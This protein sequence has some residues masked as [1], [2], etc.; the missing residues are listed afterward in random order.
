MK[1][2]YFFLMKT[3]VVLS[4]FFAVAC[5][6][7]NG[8]DIPRVG[9][10]YQGGIV[11]Y[12]DETGKH[13]LI[14][15][16]E[17]QSPGIQWYNGSYIET[18]A[19]AIAIGT[20]KSNTEKIIEE[21]SAGTYAAKLCDDLVLNGYSDWFLPSKDELNELYKNRAEIGGFSNTSIKTGL[22]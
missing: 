16:P 2:N 13:G 5:S 8:D 19:T 3:F 4:L 18:G 12:I 20:G 22:R 15:A 14:A 7:D 17:D 6:S 1:K 11:A 9:Q 21:Q 10:P